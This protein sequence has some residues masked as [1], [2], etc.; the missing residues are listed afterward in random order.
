MGAA[1]AL[2]S[3]GRSLKLLAGAAL[4]AA[5]VPMATAADTLRDALVATYGTSPTLNAQ[6]EALKGS[7]AAVALANAQGRPQIA[8]QVG[9][10]RD[11]TRS[12]VLLTNRSKGPILSG[13]LDVNLPLFAGGRIRNAMDAAK[14]RVEAGRAALRAVEGDVFAEAVEVYMDVLRDRAVLDLN[15]NQVRVLTENLRATKQ[16][17]EAGDLTRTDIAQSD[18]RLSSAKAQLALAQSRL[19]VSEESFLRVVGKRPETLASP[20]PL[21]PLPATA[22]EATRIAIAR[23]PRLTAALQQ[24]R[25]AGMDVKGTFADRLPT[26]SG[27]VGG[28]YINYVGDEPGIGVPRSGVQTSVGLTTRIPLYQGGAP[29]ARIRQ[30]RAAEGQ[31]L[32]QTVATERLVVANAR[33]AFVTYQAAL[34]AIGSNRD[35]VSANELALRGTRAE[36]SVGSRT[37]IEVLNAEQELLGSRVEL[38]AARRDAYVAGFRLL[39]AMG[40]ASSEELGL[41]GGALYDPTGNYDKV[42]GDWSDWGGAGQH[43]V[44]STSTVALAEAAPDRLAEEPRLAAVEPAPV[45]TAAKPAP[46]ALLAAKPVAPQAKASGTSGGWVIQLGAFARPGAPQALFAKVASRVG[47]KEPIYLPAGRVT[48]LLVGTYASRAEAEAAC[49]SLGPATPCLPLRRD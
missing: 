31:L 46:P 48:R 14:A 49:S 36:R 42:A 47:G 19:S 30:A 17:Y 21:P 20:P 2:G 39:Q 7:D 34:K 15:Q 43:K 40:M 18:A 45:P 3:S 35:A 13:G 27:T 23:N 33:S 5:L 12:G 16:L 24:A 10:N 32:E 44:R 6:R 37:V 26:L 38:I 41:N 22:T 28:D 29:A 11:L 25:A 1:T 9:V 8:A 4:A